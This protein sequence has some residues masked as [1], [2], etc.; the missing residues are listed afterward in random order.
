MLWSAN[1]HYSI[2]ITFYNIGNILSSIYDESTKNAILDASNLHIVAVFAVNYNIYSKS[3][4][5]TL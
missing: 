4:P 5:H 1:I 3:A 2:N